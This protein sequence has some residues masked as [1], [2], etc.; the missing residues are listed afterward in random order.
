MLFRVKIFVPMGTF[1]FFGMHKKK[2]LG[3]KIGGG[4]IGSAFWAVIEISS[5]GFFFSKKIPKKVG[6]KL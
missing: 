4:K 3:K 1:V 6:N 5:G 2:V